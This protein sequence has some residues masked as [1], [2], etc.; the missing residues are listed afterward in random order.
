V[1]FGRPVPVPDDDKG[2]LVDVTAKVTKVLDDGTVKVNVTASFEGKS[3]LGGAS[4]LVRLP[5]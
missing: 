3:V 4:A 1:R 2:A 5:A